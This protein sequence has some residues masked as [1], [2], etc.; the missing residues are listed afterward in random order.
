MK[1]D[2]RLKVISVNCYSGCKVNERPIDFNIRGKDLKVE[3]IVDRWYGIDYSYFKIL[4][5][6]HK[7]YI[8]KYDQDKDLWTLERILGS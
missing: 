5:N 8:I 7:V 2:S 4:A 3:K 6:D 1:V